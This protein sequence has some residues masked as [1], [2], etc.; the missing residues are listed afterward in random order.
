MSKTSQNK[1][2]ICAYLDK[3]RFKETSI[4]WQHCLKT[5]FALVDDEDVIYCKRMR[6][7]KADLLIKIG[8]QQR[9]VCIK[10]GRSTVIH[11]E[12]IFSFVSF[13]RS[14]DIDK[15]ICATLLFYHFGDGSIKGDGQNRME[16]YELKEKYGDYFEE[17]NLALQE[18]AVLQTVIQ[19]S[20]CGNGKVDYFYFGSPAFGYLCPYQSVVEFLLKK[21]IHPTTSFYF[22]PLSIQPFDRNL[23]NEKEKE[24]DRYIVLL[25]WPGLKEDMKSIATGRLAML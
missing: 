24:K 16:V 13:L 23:G 15:A 17:A 14:L 5:M 22:G 9:Y 1:E 10:D 4:H 7:K 11:R 21:K 3:K 25:K 8:D 20:L 19:R 2:E 18:D 12:D 6:N